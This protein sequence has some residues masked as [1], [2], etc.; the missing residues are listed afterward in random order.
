MPVKGGVFALSQW[1]AY[2]PDCRALRPMGGGGPLVRYLGYSPLQIPDGSCDLSFSIAC[3]INQ[4]CDFVKWI[5]KFFSDRLENGLPARF[6]RGR[7]CL[8]QPRNSQRRRASGQ[9]RRRKELDFS[10]REWT[11]QDFSGQDWTGR[12]AWEQVDVRQRAILPI[13]G[14]NTLVTTTNYNYNNTSHFYKIAD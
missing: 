10:G 2:L 3:I 7:K 5:L 11:R 6:G 13:N 4:L 9:I 12:Y 14:V 8:W 1:F